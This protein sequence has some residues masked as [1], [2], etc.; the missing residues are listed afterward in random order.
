[1]RKPAFCICEKTKTQISLAVTA[2]LISAFVFAIQIVKSLFYLNPKF[3]ASS[4]LLWLYCP[5]CVGPGRKPRRQVFS[6]RGS[7]LWIHLLTNN[8]LG[9]SLQLQKANHCSAEKS[10]PVKCEMKSMDFLF[11]LY[12]DDRLLHSDKSLKQFFSRKSST[13]PGKYSCSL[14]LSQM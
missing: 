13:F 11:I 2:K 5:V 9:V 10:I 4:H 7:N 8:I 3:L 1:M 12:I 14:I 6:E